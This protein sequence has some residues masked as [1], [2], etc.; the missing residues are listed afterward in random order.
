VPK[1]KGINVIFYVCKRCCASDEGFGA[2]SLLA[3]GEKL[4]VS[5]IREEFGKDLCRSDGIAVGTKSHN[6]ILREGGNRFGNEKSSIICKT[7]L[8]YLCGR[9]FFDFLGSL[10]L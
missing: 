10:V 3:I 9:V 7:L 4:L 2:V 5:V 6:L 8:D 1:L